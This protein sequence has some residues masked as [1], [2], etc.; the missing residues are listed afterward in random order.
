MVELKR[1]PMSS[2]DGATWTATIDGIGALTAGMMYLFIPDRTTSTTTPTLNVNGFGDVAIRRKLGAGTATLSALGLTSGFFANRPVLLMYDTATYNGTPY[3]IA[4]EFTKPVGSDLYG[5]VPVQNGGWYS[6]SNTTDEDLVEA[7]E[8]F[9]VYSKEEQEMVLIYDSGEITEAVNSIAGIDISGYKNIQ[10][11]VQNTNDGTNTSSAAGA[12]VF[13]AKNGTTYIFHTW[14]NLFYTTNGN[15]TSG[16]AHFKLLNGWL[17]LEHVA[18]SAN[19]VKKIFT[20]TEGG[21]AF[22]CSMFNGGA[23]IRC[24]NELS[25]LAVTSQ[26][27]SASNFFGVGSR[28]MVWGCKA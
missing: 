15:T 28:V 16:I 9:G 21:S 1:F 18:T 5:K 26:N 4:M 25:T 7:R 12:V 2:T 13:T 11:A 22:K 17:M 24:T 19:Q 20:E 8:A 27:Q 6:N 23:L 14:Q 3:W 10:I